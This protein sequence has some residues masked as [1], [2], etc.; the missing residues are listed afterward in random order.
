[1]TIFICHN[2]LLF[3]GAFQSPVHSGEAL[4]S[5]ATSIFSLLFRQTSFGLL[6]CA[7]ESKKRNESRNY[8][9]F[10]HFVHTPVSRRKVSQWDLHAQICRK[11]HLLCYDGAI[12]N[13]PTM[14]FHS[15]WPFGTSVLFPVRSAP[16]S[17]RANVFQSCQKGDCYDPGAVVFV[18]SDCST[19]LLQVSAPPLTFS[20]S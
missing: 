7:H 18:L 9:N 4:H 13:C 2:F 6:W 1:M 20:Y 11:V 17:L 16:N 19:L 14:P 15:L 8:G 12:T 5:R 10:V 3:W